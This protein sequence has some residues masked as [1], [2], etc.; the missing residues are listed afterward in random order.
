MRNLSTAVAKDR[1]VGNLLAAVAK[2][3]TVRYLSAAVTKDRTV[4][5]LLAAIAEDR[6]V[7]NFQDRECLSTIGGIPCEGEYKQ[8]QNG[9]ENEFACKKLLH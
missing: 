8:S 7:G 1:T 3:R 9:G 2:D 6:T 4:G 5:N